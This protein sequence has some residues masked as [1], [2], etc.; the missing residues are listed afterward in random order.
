MANQKPQNLKNHGRFVPLFHMFVLPVFL[1]NLVGSIIHLVR[2]GISYGSVMGVLMALALF[3]LAFFAQQP[4]DLFASGFIM[5]N[6]QARPSAP[7]LS[8]P[9]PVSFNLSQLAEQLRL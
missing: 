6:A 3:M 8:F 1:I 7:P 4:N 5:C 9:P 2:A